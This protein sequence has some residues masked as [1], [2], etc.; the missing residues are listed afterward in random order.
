MW[1]FY[2]MEY[3]KLVAKIATAKTYRNSITIAKT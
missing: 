1:I 3:L 2:E